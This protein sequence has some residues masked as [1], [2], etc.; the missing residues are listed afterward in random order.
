MGRSPV[1]AKRKFEYQS[2][3]KTLQNPRNAL[4]FPPRS[5]FGSSSTQPHKNFGERNNQHPSNMSYGGQIQGEASYPRQQPTQRPN[6]PFT[7]LVY[8]ACNKS[9]LKAFDCPEKKNRTPAPAPC[10]EKQVSSDSTTH[11]S[12]STHPPDRR[13]NQGCT[14]RQGWRLPPRGT[15]SGIC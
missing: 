3:D 7:S 15:S 1:L 2:R 14:L 6:T 4:S 5:N 12:W 9:G 10:S 13:E 8:Y 11:R